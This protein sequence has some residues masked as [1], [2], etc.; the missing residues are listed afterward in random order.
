MTAIQLNSARTAVVTGASSGNG[1]AVALRLAAEGCRV[2]C[3]DLRPEALAGG[4]EQEADVPTHELIERSGGQ[5]NFAT[6]DVTS[7]TQ[8]ADLVA[9][10]V[11]TYGR[12]DVMVNNAGITASIGNTI[13]ESEADFDRT[14]AVNLKGVW[15]G[16]K[17]AITQQSKQDLVDGCRGKVVNIASIGGLVGLEK[18]PA[19]CASKGGVVNLTRQLAIDFAPSRINVSAV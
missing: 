10:T 17:Y 9:T 5:A 4:Y 11:A 14:M 12:L 1:R 18:E 2:V 3:A 13:E 6:C 8:V 16:A 19:Y 15:L 7:A